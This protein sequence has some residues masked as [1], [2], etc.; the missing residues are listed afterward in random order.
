MNQ[1]KTIYIKKLMKFIKWNSAYYIYLFLF[2]SF[3]F[4]SAANAQNELSNYLQTAAQNNPGL[5]AKFNAY[6]AALEVAPQVKALP[7]PQVAFGYFIQPVETRV[8]PQ[9]FKFSAIQMFPWFGTLK[10]KENAAIQTA[11]A[12][13]ELFEEAKSMLYNDVRSTWYNLYF[14]NKA[15]DIT[16]KNIDILHTFRQLA[17][18]KVE[19]GLVSAVDEYRIE[20]EIGDLENQLALLRDKHYVLEVLFNKLLNVDNQT[21]I[22]IPN[23]LWT[24]DFYLS[25]NAALDSLRMNN[26][27]LLSIDLQ[28]EA[29]RYKKEVADK[30]GKPNFS[31]GLDY[32]MVG[33]GENNM[34]GTD[35]FM[36]PKVG[37]TIPLYRNKYKAMVKEVVYLETAKKNEKANKTNVLETLFEN[38]WKDYK[39][40][41]RRIGLYKSQLHL[42]QKS[43]KI[44]ETDYATGNRNFEEILRMERKYL[45]YALELEKAKADKQAAISFITY[46]MGN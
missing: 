31:L 30:A 37:I 28:M 26:H 41:D 17:Y 35:A 29:L 12:K 6:M 32:T 23:D 43:L 38:G 11:K 10:A 9:E 13:Y 46:L 24:T 45:K 14:N 18:V 2:I 7:D 19:A 15:I 40:G 1:D 39:D 22:V 3:Y 4:V 25:K 27:Q 8:G 21:P 16:K 20:M 36:F 33:K 34:A 5:K 42:A 44:L